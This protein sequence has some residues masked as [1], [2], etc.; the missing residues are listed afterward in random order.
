MT[1]TPTSVCSTLNPSDRS[2]ARPTVRPSDR[3]HV[4]PFVRPYVR[5]TV[6]PHVRPPVR[7][8][9]EPPPVYGIPYISLHKIKKADC[10]MQ[11][12]SFILEVM[13][14][15]HFEDKTLILHDTFDFFDLM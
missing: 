11:M 8:G 13:T 7:Y 3:P 1:R 2:S 5:P 9:M 10:I 6:R 14:V 12:S 4:R 15:S